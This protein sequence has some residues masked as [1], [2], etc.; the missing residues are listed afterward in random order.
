MFIFL[1]CVEESGAYVTTET[2]DNK[3]LVE[4]ENYNDKSLQRYGKINCINNYK[5]C[6]RLMKWENQNAGIPSYIL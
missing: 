4:K 3:T 6:Y 2:N 5:V 1:P